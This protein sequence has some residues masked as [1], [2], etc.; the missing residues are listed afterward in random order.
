MKVAVTDRDG[1]GHELEW[2]AADTLMETLRDQ[3]M[4]I[5]AS[6]GGQRSCATCHVYVDEATFAK[7]GE[8]EGEERELLEET[9]HFRPEASRLSCQLNCSDELEGIQVTIAPEDF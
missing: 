1:A 7:V 2:D 5:L 6:C 4:P 8:A 9:E 3:G